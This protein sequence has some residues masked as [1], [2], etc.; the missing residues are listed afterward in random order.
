[1]KKFFEAV[2]QSWLAETN[3]RIKLQQVYAAAAILLAAIGGFMIVVAP[4]FA[5]FVTMAAA[6]VALL[7]IINAVAWA[8]LRGTIVEL[9]VDSAKP[10]T[11]KKPVARKKK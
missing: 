3:Q 9:T 8:L 2:Y 7:F 5:Q 11:A 4:Y 1:M 6:A 10:A